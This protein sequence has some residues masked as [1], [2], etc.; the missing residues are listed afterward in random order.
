MAFKN[1]SEVNPGNN[2]AF[3][4]IGSS[5]LVTYTVIAHGWRTIGGVP[6]T[7]VLR[8]WAFEAGNFSGGTI[9]GGTDTYNGSPLDNRMV[10][11]LNGRIPTWL[12]GQIPS[13]S[14]PIRNRSTGAVTNISRNIFALSEGEL[15]SGPA[16]GPHIP[17]FSSNAR[18]RAGNTTAGDRPY[19]TRTPDLNMSGLARQAHRVSDTG[20]M[21]SA[22]QSN[23]VRCRPAFLLPAN[24]TVSETNGAVRN[25]VNLTP[26]APGSVTVVRN[27]AAL[28]NN[29]V[30]AGV[31]LT[32]NWTA[33]TPGTGST[34]AQVTYTLQ[35][36]YN[37]ERDQDRGV[38]GIPI[39]SA[40]R[41]TTVATGISGLTHTMSAGVPAG[42]NTAHF[43]VI[44]VDQHASSRLNTM[45]AI[46][47]V[48]TNSPP[49][50][51]ASIATPANPF[52]GDDIRITWG[53]S[54]DPD[55]NLAGFRIQRSV[56]GGTWSQVFQGAAR[57]FSETVQTAW[58]SVQYR[59][60]AFDTF[61][62]QS[63]WMNSP[64]RLP[65]DRVAITVAQDASSDIRNGMTITTDSERTVVFRVSNNRDTNMT[66]RYTAILTLN[67]V[68]VA[69][70][71]NQVI[72]GGLFTLD[73]SVVQWQQLLNRQHTY[74]LTVTDVSGNT[75]QGRIEFTKNVTRV[76]LQ[77]APIFV[78]ISNNTPIRNFL[79]N[80]LGAMR[81]DAGATLLVEITNNANDPVPVWQP[82]TNDQL[83]SGYHS[84]HNTLVQNGNYFAFRLTADRGTS[85][86]PC[87]ID[88]ISG[89]AGLSQTFILG[90]ENELLREELDT[91]T[92]RVT[93]LEQLPSGGL[94]VPTPIAL[95]S[96][97]V[98]A[99][100]EPG[101]SWKVK[102]C[103]VTAPGHTGL[104]WIMDDGTLAIFVDPISIDDTSI[105]INPAGNM[106]VDPAWAA[107]QLA[108]I[109][110]AINSHATQTIFSPDGVHGIRFYNGILQ[111]FDGTEW[112]D[113]GGTPPQPIQ[114][115]LDGSWNLDGSVNLD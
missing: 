17:Y 5:S 99:G 18:R 100:H 6:H 39:L 71:V 96:Q 34:Q 115:I 28:D 74:T 76:I 68:Q 56:N 111:G 11:M 57:E 69:S 49:T 50:T 108:P 46:Q 81:L 26:G 45:S 105:T 88:K 86:Q 12:R 80:I 58:E 78:D 10:A 43:R 95:E 72:D 8:E 110:Q 75:A 20:A 113:I 23:S 24:L 27:H 55:G 44:A 109:L 53:E 67:G 29:Q 37:N 83:N 9:G 42:T 66:A 14:I 82:L 3:A 33:A 60:A 93:S 63:G 36:N 7:L 89:I 114:H 48:I 54:T 35:R 41:W 101:D 2:I 92:K 15:T 85:G 70:R 90:Q 79:M 64:I 77:S 84:I 62:A 65:Q 112:V 31:A 21:G 40:L 1:L 98:P 94:R 19:W 47:T 59:V 87:W 61:D 104:A 30:L 16:D 4:E 106:Q 97:I 13:I 73:L 52:R 38:L 102:N 51:P 103:D 25:P 91:L 32:I 22:T 107:S